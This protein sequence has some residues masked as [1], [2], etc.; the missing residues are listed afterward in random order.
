MQ[1]IFGRENGLYYYISKASLKLQQILHINRLRK[2]NLKISCGAN[3]FSITHALASY[4][5]D[6][7]ALIKRLC[8]QGFC[9]DEIFLQTLVVNSDFIK[10]VYK[11]NDNEDY[12]SSMRYIDWKRGAPYTF[13][14]DD[15]NDLINYDYLFARKFNIQ[16]EPEICYDIFNFVTGNSNNELG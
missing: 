11:L 10:N 2:F 5:L 8:K 16:T 12:I 15:Y 14:K 3:W 7:E 9:V 1:E 13:C 4:I 6:N